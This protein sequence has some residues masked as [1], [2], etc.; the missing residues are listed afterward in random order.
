MLLARLGW[1]ERVW[2]KVKCF[3]VI[4]SSGGWPIY[5]CLLKVVVVIFDYWMLWFI[6][7]YSNTIGLGKRGDLDCKYDCPWP[8]L[9]AVVDLWSSISGQVGKDETKP[10]RLVPQFLEKK[11]SG[12]CK[13]FNLEEQGVAN[14]FF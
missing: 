9:E 5:C 14:F 2:T 12:R 7:Y 11:L 6:L 1:M 4:F 10:F 13:Q 3:F 8:F